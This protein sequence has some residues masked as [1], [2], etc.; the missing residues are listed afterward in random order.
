MIAQ[1]LR[2]L[3]KQRRGEWQLHRRR[4]IFLAAR[5]LEGISAFDQLALDISCFTANA[6]QLV[7]TGVIR[8]DLVPGD[9][10]IDDGVVL[11]QLL[12]AVALHGFRVQ[13][14]KIGDIPWTGGAPVFPR[15]AG[16]GAGQKIAK[17]AD[18]H[19][20]IAHVVAQRDRLLRIILHHAKAHV[21]LE[22]VHAAEVVG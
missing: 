6:H 15:A 19:G 18:G 1:R 10:P 14:E 17:L 8:L 3:F 11:G 22:L 16:A 20:A 9:A 2:R 21:E 13:L 7:A 5:A 12:D 4:R